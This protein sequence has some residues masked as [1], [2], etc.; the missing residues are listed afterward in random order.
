MTTFISL[1]RGINVSGKNKIKMQELR[2]LYEALGFH[3]VQSYVQSGN[4]VFASDTIN[5]NALAAC[6]A[7]GIKKEFGLEV[8]V[9]VFSYEH[10]AEM[11]QS[12]PFCQSGSRDEKA[13]YYTF[14]AEK[15]ADF[16]EAALRSKMLP[17]EEIYLSERV[18]Y[19]YCPQSY[20]DTKLSNNFLESKLKV[21]A[22]TRNLRTCNTLLEMGNE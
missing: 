2:A 20:S 12:N 19:L 7:Q 4:V 16:A 13:I 14:L 18:V 6:I 1:L 3:E 9:L 11:V 22:T 17:E 15:P 5:A 21:T 8:P 10:F